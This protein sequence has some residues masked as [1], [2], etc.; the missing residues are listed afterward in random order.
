MNTTVNPAVARYSGGI[1][2]LAT[3]VGYALVGISIAL[4]W[5]VREQNLI[6]AQDGLGYWLGII[7]GSL[8]LLLLIYPLRKRIRWLAGLGSVKAWFR[9]HMIFGVVGPLLILFHSNFVLGSLNG[10][11]ALFATLIVA[12]SGIIGRYLYGKIH[13]GMYGQ[14]ATLMSLQAEVEIEPAPTSRMFSI[15]ALVDER[16]KPYERRVL[17]RSSRMLP[18]V[19]DALCTPLLA[20]RLKWSLKRALQREVDAR[21][22]ESAVL[23]QHRERL[24]KA[25]EDYLSRRLTTYRRYAQISGCERLFSLWHIVHFPLFLV[26]VVAAIVHVFAVHAY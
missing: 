18:S 20:V 10:R 11:I 23:A 14:R 19:L 17:E 8:M 1:M 24:L 26:M 2:K 4:L 3:V 5:S 9:T 13:Y 7:G 25:A 16:L 21:A 6:R 12:A 22:A 15:V